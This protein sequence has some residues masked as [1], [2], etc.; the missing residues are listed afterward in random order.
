MKQIVVATIVLAIGLVLAAGCGKEAET[1]NPITDP[2]DF[3][4][5]IDNQYLPLTPGTT[6]IYEGETE[7]GSERNEVY[8]SHQTKQ[9][10]G[11]SCVEVRDM[12]WLEG[13][14]IEATLDWY[15]QDKDGNVWYFGED[16]KEYQNGEVVSTAGSWQAGVDGAK[17]GIIMEAN[18]KAGDSYR[19]GDSYRQE[20]Y[21]GEAEDMAQIL[22][23]GESVTVAYGSFG[24][25]LKTREYTPLEPG[26]AENKYYA[27]GVGHVLTVMVTGGS[28][29]VE[30]VDITAE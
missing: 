28:E 19:S 4:T 10:L 29:R 20:Y 2:A 11:V 7:E 30:L 18:P 24:N 16:S 17:P 21:K 1:Y 9:I 5:T 15:A 14:L 6:F 13:D 25:C 27:P 26:V 22:S 12:V 23:L 8:V 3:V